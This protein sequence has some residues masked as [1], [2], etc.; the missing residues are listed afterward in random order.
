M[1]F[2][3]Y[4]I[5]MR[6]CGVAQHSCADHCYTNNSSLHYYH[7]RSCIYTRP[8]VGNISLWKHLT[9]PFL[10]TYL[11]LDPYLSGPYWY[12]PSPYELRVYTWY[13]ASLGLRPREVSKNGP[14]RGGSICHI[15]SY[16]VRRYKYNAGRG[17][18][19]K[20][21]KN[22]VITAFAL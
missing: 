4:I 15:Q 8:N 10:F 19:G 18:K 6:Q 7:V 13:I 5:Y 17:G 16:P 14:D 1:K 2:R 11:Q 3:S 12:R 9:L 20:R 21:A 22:R